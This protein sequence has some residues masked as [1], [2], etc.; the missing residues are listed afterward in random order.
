MIYARKTSETSH[1]QNNTKKKGLGPH[2]KKFMYKVLYKLHTVVF[3]I[4][5]L[6]KLLI[7]VY[8]YVYNLCMHI[9]IILSLIQFYFLSKINW[10]TTSSV[11]LIQEDI[12]STKH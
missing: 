6:L 4:Y 1:L 11:D 3:K 10:P 2:I 9:Y 12:Y 8:L 7:Y 5:F